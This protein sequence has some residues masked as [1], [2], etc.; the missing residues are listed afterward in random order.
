MATYPDQKFDRQWVYK[1]ITKEVVEWTDSFGKFLCSD[2][3]D[4]GPLTTGQLR[5]FF[6]EVK[7]VDINIGVNKADI[8]MLKP[9]LAYA[10]GRDKKDGGKNKTKIDKFAE[11]MNKGIDAVLDG[12]D[13]KS[14]FSHFVKIFEAIVAYHKFYG[15]KE[16]NR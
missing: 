10:V 4:T 2:R 14:D 9:L 7:R 12:K 15:A 16:N 1:G 11:E 5:K 8:I 3:Q 6:G 13:L